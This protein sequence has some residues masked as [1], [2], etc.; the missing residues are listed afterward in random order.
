MAE[1][2]RPTWHG[3]D[4]RND[5]WLYAFGRL[6]AGL[7]R[8]QAEE[9]LNVPFTAV[10]RERDFAALERELGDQARA[11]F[12]ARRIVLEDGSRPRSAERQA[13]RTALLLLLAVT[14]FVLLIACANVANLL[15]TR[16]ADRA[17]EIALRLSL[18]ASPGRLTRW[19]LTEACLLGILGG[20]SA[21]VVARLSLD[22]LVALA[23]ASAG[24]IDH[25]PLDTPVWLFALLLGL[26][27]GLLFGMFPAV[28]AVRAAAAHGLRTQ[29]GRTTG[30]RA[31]VR[32]RA[33]LATTQ[34]ALATALLVLA[35]LC[36]LSLSNLTRV[37]L[38]FDRDGLVLFGISPHLNGY[39]PEQTRALVDELH[40]ALDAMPGVRSISTTTIPL[41][42]GWDSSQNL[43]VEGF[44]ADSGT[45]THA[46]RASIGPGYFR[47]LGVP[48]V[49][50]REFTPADTA[51]APAVAIVNE[52][53]AR[54]FH[55]GTDA[56]GRRIALGQG[57]NHRPDI[58]IVGLVRDAAYSQ[59]RD[60]TPPQ[61]F[62]PHRQ[63]DQGALTFF[64]YV[65]SAGNVRPVL[66]AIR[67]AVSRLAP[68]LPVVSLRTMDEQ[69]GNAMAGD[70]I[71]AT[72]TGAF[73]ALAT[74]LAGIGL[75]AVLAY[76]VARRMHEIG[77]RMALGATTGAI[78][79]T[80]LRQVLTITLIGTSLGTTAALGI[81]RVGRTL[82]YGLDG[83]EPGVLGGAVGLVVL[84]TLA[85][86]IVPAR[87]AASV[88][89]V[90]ALRSE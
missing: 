50:G 23:P 33:A 83:V 36:L 24:A 31:V 30:S 2:M 5:H 49:A 34:T 87:R 57:T 11:E 78:G 37:E 14:G 66:D 17:A 81:G 73:A 15:L 22:A 7:T 88:N 61:F 90:E 48:L 84:V 16:A 26:G 32:F 80:V 55:L 38:G 64:F 71:V 20:A 6:A 62:L 44:D 18:G 41:L 54:K 43:T 68:G 75:Y 85:A 46:K 58:E 72:F 9:R 45:D 77:I 13:A 63:A 59:V 28:H 42:S 65:R 21:L 1:P 27:T 35:G 25:L 86:A 40:A 3:L 53:F 39:T 82:L 10:L 76:G 79:R 70:R 29:T 51:G 67:P 47:T 56:V 69:V 19:L 4:A 74:L 89:P 8:R 52:A 60:G 12:L